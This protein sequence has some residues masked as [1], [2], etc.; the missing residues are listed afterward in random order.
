MSATANPTL[1]HT[2]AP[3]LDLAPVPLARPGRWVAATLV[4]LVL[5]W[6]VYV[7]V[8]NPNFQWRVVGKYLFSKE[9]LYGVKLTSAFRDMEKRV[10]TQRSK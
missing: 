4:F 8:N 7:V 1:P 9:I 3:R 5:V 2:G 10:A 6:F